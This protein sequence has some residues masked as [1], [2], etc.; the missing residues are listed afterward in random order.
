MTEQETTTWAWYRS[1]KF[2]VLLVLAVQF[3]ALLAIVLTSLYLVN[4]RQHDYVI[5]NLTGQLRVI[6]QNLSTQ[7]KHYSEQGPGERA[8][9]GRD[10]GPFQ[11][12]L[13]M[14]VEA[15]DRII[16]SLKNRSIEADLVNPHALTE[17]RTTKPGVPSLLQQSEPIICN[18]NRESRN[19]MDATAA[20][21]DQFL[22]GLNIHLGKNG[23]S[24]HLEKAAL[25]ITGNAKDLSQSTA[26]LANTFRTMMEDKLL[27]I[28]ML[29][30]AAIGIISTISLTIIFILFQRVFR[31]ID[32]TVAGF[33][34]V[35]RGELAFQVPILD[36]NEIGA[37]TES[38]NDLTTRL[39]T[40]FKLS[41]QINQTDN[42]D[43]TLKYVFEC[44]PVFF[45]INWVGLLR[46][47]RNNREYHI[48][49]SFCKNTYSLKEDD[50]YALPGSL[51]RQTAVN[52]KPF[53]NCTQQKSARG[54][55]SDEFVQKLGA[56]ALRSFFYLPIS[57][58]PL[59]TAVL[60]LA[61]EQVDAYNADHLEFLDNIAGQVG[62]SF[63]KTIGM[64]S[65]VISSIKGL[66]N[67]AES[68]DPETGDHLFRMSHY[69]ALIAEELA[70]EAEYSS[71]I[72]QHYIRD[73][74][75][76]APMHDI[77]KVGISDDILLKAGKL[78]AAQFRIM[79]Q[80]PVIGGGVLRRCEEQMNA[81]GRSIF[82]IGIEIAEC[83]HEKY[84]GSGYP[85]QLEGDAI[86]LSARI[87]AAADVFDALTSK[88]PY[89][90]AWT[91][92]A[93]ADYL[94]QESGRHFDPA[95]V[96]HFLAKLKE[97]VAV[98]EQYREPAV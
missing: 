3:F 51:F 88:R 18:W 39:S 83:H 92:E 70:K 54:W 36:R 66:A 71:L 11:K 58:N 40:L 73:I 6:N 55:H 4:L 1:I 44:F 37:M 27:Q 20:V 25:Y 86:P 56:N 46:S 41:D 68:R 24:R 48:D 33:R 17:S 42:V 80:H 7:A 79:Q 10:P 57:S 59:E 77:G 28:Q 29:N 5:L 43:D 30:N 8:S 13:L 67:L 78:D 65:L 34:R 82:R 45:P 61:C 49:R 50:H 47:S 16:R 95:L 90:E 19:Q 23:D 62:R 9:S 93:A 72:N 53:C 94:Q 32:R 2:Q 97:I 22:A 14:Q 38:F 81:V 89:K 15:F 12:D 64:E 98:R 26:A 75:R 96:Q 69:S 60:V 85:N 87:V 74:L 21:W 76:F 31:P 35:A 52:N 91:I 84:D 63:E